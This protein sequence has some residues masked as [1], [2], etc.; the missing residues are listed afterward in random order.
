MQC[1]YSITSDED[2]SQEDGDDY[3]D[4]LEER[5]RIADSLPSGG[6]VKII[7]PVDDDDEVLDEGEVLAEF[8]FLVSEHGGDDGR[9]DGKV[10]RQ[11]VYPMYS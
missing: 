6:G 8:D 11:Y 9:T 5:R 1:V 4:D 3:D 2:D 10:A 7:D